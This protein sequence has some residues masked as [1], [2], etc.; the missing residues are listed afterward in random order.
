MARSGG[1][2]RIKPRQTTEARWEAGF[3]ADS[4]GDAV[5]T[6]WPAEEAG[7]KNFAGSLRMRC[8]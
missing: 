4:G 6:E 2:A 3:A 8:G 7:A 5:Q 1:L